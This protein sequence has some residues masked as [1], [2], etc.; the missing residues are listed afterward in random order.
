M[1]Q[2]F[3]LPSYAAHFENVEL[4]FIGSALVDGGPQKN[5][6]AVW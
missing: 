5:A 1:W 4:G 6:R 2:R 3:S